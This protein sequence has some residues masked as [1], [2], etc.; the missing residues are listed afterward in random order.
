V[1][2]AAPAPEPSSARVARLVNDSDRIEVVGPAIVRTPTGG[3]YEIQT[4]VSLRFAA[5]S[6]VW[7]KV[8]PEDE[9]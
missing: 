4:A 9:S 3:D 1:S 6:D 8:W 7:L 5:E 2:E